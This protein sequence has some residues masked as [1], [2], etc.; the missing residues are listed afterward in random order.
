MDLNTLAHA[1]DVLNTPPMVFVTNAMPPSGK[2][3]WDTICEGA[4]AIVPFAVVYVAWQQWKLSTRQHDL[5]KNQLK[6]SEEQKQIARGKLKL[7]VFEKRYELYKSFKDKINEFRS[8]IFKESYDNLKNVSNSLLAMSHE[9][10]FIYDAEVF[11]EVNTIMESIL[12][13]VS[14]R[15]KY[16]DSEIEHDDLMN[17]ASLCGSIIIN[18]LV[19]IFPNLVKPFLNLEELDRL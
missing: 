2:G 18:F 6:L 10:I 7:E 15:R 8:N 17:E 1:P 4:R 5:Q 3:W 14:S 13:L 9:F 12:M 19:N 16:E 11:L